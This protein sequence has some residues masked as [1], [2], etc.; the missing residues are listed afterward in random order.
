M[1]QQNKLG[2][3]TASS[4]MIT[5]TAIIIIIRGDLV[6]EP[7]QGR[8]PFSRAFLGRTRHSNH[9]K[10]EG[11]KNIAKNLLPK[12]PSQRNQDKTALL[13]NGPRK[14]R[15]ERGSWAWL[16]QLVLTSSVN[17]FSRAVNRQEI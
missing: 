9:V 2:I 5:L 13:Q 15:A 4:V 7:E 10:T 16:H 11:T 17:H 6:A 3:F 12:W 1:K 14:E 8:K